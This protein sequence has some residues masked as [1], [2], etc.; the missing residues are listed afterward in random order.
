[1]RVLCIVNP[2]AG[3]GRAARTW[4]A[5]ERELAALRP[6]LALTE[7]PGHAT[8][9]ARRACADGFTHLLAV[10]GDGTLHEVINGIDRP[11]VALAVVPAGTANDFARSARIPFRPEAAVRGLGHDRRR[12]IDVGTVHGRRYLNVAGAGFDA[13]VA[14]LINAGPRRARGALPYV[15]TAVALAF[16]YRAAELELDLDGRRL[17]RRCLLVAVGNAAAYGGGMRICPDAVLDDGLLDVCIVGELAPAKIL[18]ILP[19]VFFARHV[20]HPAVE[21]VRARAVTITGPGA[22]A[23]HADGEVSGTLPA[24]FRL[25]AG[26]CSLW[27]PE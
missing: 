16:R 18:A 21:Y 5:V 13:E 19:T 3:N 24:H 25:E 27:V 9:I 17:R 2:A 12:T 6:E 15:A 23:V 8:A 4:A 22:C 7:S 1:V 14:R 11:G 20:R 10:G 26:A